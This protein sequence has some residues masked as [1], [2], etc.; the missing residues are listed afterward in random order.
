MSSVATTTF[1]TSL[2]VVVFGMDCGNNLNEHDFETMLFDVVP[3]LPH[4]RELHASCH[5]I[6]SIGNIVKRLRTESN[7]KFPSGL[8]TLSM[9]GNPFFPRYT[10][11]PDEKFATIEQ[12][13]DAMP[14]VSNIGEFKLPPSLSYRLYLNHA[15]RALLQNKYTTTNNAMSAIPVSL[16]PHVL[17]RH[18]ETASGFRTMTDGLRKG[19]DGVYHILRRICERP[20]FGVHVVL[21][22]PL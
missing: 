10:G 11:I 22:K 3:W 21:T 6:E 7:L 1:P 14:L 16:W 2:Q 8:H 19:M 12:F 4:L 18:M 17:A 20:D 13:V 15:G 5:K 9:D